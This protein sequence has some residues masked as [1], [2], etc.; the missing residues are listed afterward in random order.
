[1][2]LT[3]MRGRSGGML[4]T[5]SPDPHIIALLLNALSLRAA[6][7]VH[8]YNL[9]ATLLE[10][11]HL[12]EVDQGL[13]TNRSGDHRRKKD[14]VVYHPCLSEGRHPPR[15]SEYASDH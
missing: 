6:S 15:S 1:M 3:P 12:S 11:R 4:P 5:K 14:T 7:T 9:F 8:L 10:Q 13:P 2:P